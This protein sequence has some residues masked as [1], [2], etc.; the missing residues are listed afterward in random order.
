MTSGKFLVAMPCLALATGALTFLATGVLGQVLLDDYSVSDEANY[1]Y[2]PVFNNPADGWNVSSGELRPTIAGN[3]TGAWLWNRGEQLSAVGDS[4]SITLSLP[5][6]ADNQLRSSIGLFLSPQLNSA[7]S[8]MEVVLNRYPD[9][10]YSMFWPSGGIIGATI[11]G[12]VQLTI[13]LIAP[14]QRGTIYEIIASGGGFQSPE[15][16]PMFTTNT[17]SLFFGPL[18]YNTA[19]TQAGLDNLIFTPVPEPPAFAIFGMLTL[20]T[21]VTRLRRYHHTNK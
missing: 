13:K 18:A 21:A 7:S 20:A 15:G 11:S 4:V 19:G 8:M 16:G 1:N 3:A 17:S 5:T 14:M 10:S 9:G 6:G 2:L 12:P